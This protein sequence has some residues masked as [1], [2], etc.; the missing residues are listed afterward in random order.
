MRD[1]HDIP[2]ALPLLLFI[3]LGALISIAALKFIFNEEERIQ[4]NRTQDTKK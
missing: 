3:I 4:S 2:F 1:H